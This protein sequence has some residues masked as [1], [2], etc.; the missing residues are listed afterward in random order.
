MGCTNTKVGPEPADS[1][2]RAWVRGK[3]HRPSWRRVLSRVVL[4]ACGVSNKVVPIGVIPYQEEQ[5]ERTDFNKPTNEPLDAPD[6]EDDIADPVATALDE[7][8]ETTDYLDQSQPGK[9]A[10]DV[11]IID[12]E[13]DPAKMTAIQYFASRSAS[14]LPSHLPVKKAWRERPPSRGGIQLELALYG[15]NATRPLPSCLSRAVLEN[16]FR[17]KQLQD[18]VR[19]AQRMH[20]ETHLSSVRNH[21]N[22]ARAKARKPTA[23]QSCL[24]AFMQHEQSRPLTKF[25][26]KLHKVCESPVEEHTEPE[27]QQTDCSTA[28]ASSPVERPDSVCRGEYDFYF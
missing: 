2:Q 8:P 18:D 20:L 24:D 1:R 6:V 5:V 7:Q 28:D 25:G 11:G 17:D 15:K 27:P 19:R 22:R 23:A 9:E 21:G 3:M 10:E 13:A 4:P 14:P 16:N 12:L 26:R